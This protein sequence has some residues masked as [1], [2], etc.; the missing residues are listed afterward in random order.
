M[1]KIYW[2]D[3]GSL[4]D[5]WESKDNLLKNAEK[6][7]TEECTTVGE[8]IFENENYVVVAASFDGSDMY[9]DS[10]MIMKSVICKREKIN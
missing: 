2:K 3:I 6:R 8:V 4:S 5:S 1:E 10:S 9:H 7:Y